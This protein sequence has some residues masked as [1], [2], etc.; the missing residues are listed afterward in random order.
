[1]RQCLVSRPI[2]IAFFEARQQSQRVV[3]ATTR[4]SQIAVRYQRLN[5]CLRQ[6]LRPSLRQSRRLSL[7]QKTETAP[8]G[9][10]SVVS[11]THLSAV[12]G[13]QS[14]IGRISFPRRLLPKR[15]RG[16]A[17]PSYACAFARGEVN[18]HSR[19]AQTRVLRASRGPPNISRR[20]SSTRAMASTV[21]ARSRRSIGDS[22]ADR[23]AA[24]DRMA[25]SWRGTRFR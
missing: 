13:R 24:H 17:I 12:S 8:L 16:K 19:N 11:R 5:T 1:L 2:I 25:A 21:G 6:A 18:K 9:G 3:S 7:R 20:R 22:G 10:T 4:H 23:S 15:K 14:A